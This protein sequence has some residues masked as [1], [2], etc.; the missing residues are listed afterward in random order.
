MKNRKRSVSET[1]SWISDIERLFLSFDDESDEFWIFFS[2]CDEL[3]SFSSLHHESGRERWDHL[4]MNLNFAFIVDSARNWLNPL[5]KKILI[6]RKSR[7]VCSVCALY[8]I[9]LIFDRQ[10][11]RVFAIATFLKLIRSKREMSS[12]LIFMRR[13][14]TT[15]RSYAILL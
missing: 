7:I 11:Y 8:W 9:F 13:M 2:L 5:L 15:S 10:T 1:S 12:I 14:I 4:S 3:N 6:S